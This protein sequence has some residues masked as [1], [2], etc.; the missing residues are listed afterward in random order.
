M[1]TAHKVEFLLTRLHSLEGSI[2]HV[3]PQPNTI[4]H[5]MCSVQLHWKLEQSWQVLYVYLNRAKDSH[6]IPAPSEFIMTFIKA[7]RPG[8]QV[9]QHSHTISHISFNTA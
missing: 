6:G 9:L 4:L 3:C 5:P 7:K 2:S 1:P 8:G